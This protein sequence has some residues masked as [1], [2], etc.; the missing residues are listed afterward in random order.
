MSIATDVRAYADLA[1]EQGKSALTQAGSVVHNANKRL[2]ADG[3][4]PV[5]AAL[6]VA[7]LVAQSVGKRAGIVGKRVE[8]L[9]VDAVGNVA[10]AQET[11]KALLSRTQDDALARIT[12]LRGR[13]D[14]GLES[15]K[16]L[17]TALPAAAASSTS[18]YLDTAKHAYGML[19]ARGEAKLADLRKDPRVS[20]FLGELDDA[21]S[22]I[23]ARLAP[24]LGSVRSEVVPHLDSAFD[25]I[26]DADLGEPAVAP[27]SGRNSSAGTRR[28]TASRTAA[29]RPAGSRAAGRAT[30]TSRKSTAAKP[31][32]AASAKSTAGSTAKAGA[33]KAPAKASSTRARKAPA[34]KA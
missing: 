1:L 14:A 18:G 23:Q 6:G 30:P 17:P 16:S 2:A 33:R 27:H 22:A 12:E 20:K 34:R 9:P 19:T 13:L 31:G 3:P 21:S 15:A 24:V 26:K 10:R 32:N 29:S 28:S 7:D 5:L 25:A 11:G 4:K 8:S